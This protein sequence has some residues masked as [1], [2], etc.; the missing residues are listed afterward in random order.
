[1]TYLPIDRTIGVREAEQED[2]IKRIKFYKRE[3]D[4]YFDEFIDGNAVDLRLISYCVESLYD[5]FNDAVNAQ[6][7]IERI[8][9]ENERIQNERKSE[10]VG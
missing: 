7:E 9:K 6:D 8:K 4:N 10:S 5:E 1:M 2:R 3:F